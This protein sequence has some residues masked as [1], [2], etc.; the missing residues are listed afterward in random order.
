VFGVGLAATGSIADATA[1]LLSGLPKPARLGREAF[2]SY[3]ALTLALRGVVPLDRRVL[4]RLDR[5]DCLVVPLEL[6]V[7]VDLLPGSLVAADGVDPAALRAR[8]TALI[9]PGRFGEVRHEGIWSV[10][11]LDGGDARDPAT[12]YRLLALRCGEVVHGVA[13]AQVAVDPDGEALLAAARAAGMRVVVAAREPASVTGI[14]ADEIVR[15]GALPDEIRRLQR[16]G[17]VVCVVGTENATALAVA[18]C[19]IGLARRADGVPWA[20]HMLCGDR[21]EDARFLVEAC[22]TARVA[23]SQSVQLAAVGAGLGLVISLGGLSRRTSGRAATAVNVASLIAIANGVRLGAAL[24]ARPAPA[25]RDT[26]PWHALDV[27]AVMER[28]RTSLDGLGAEEALRRRLHVAAAPGTLSRLGEAVVEQLRNPLTPILAIGAGL[29]AVAGSVVDAALVATVTGLNAVVGGVQRVRTDRAIAGLADGTPLRVRVRREGVEET[30]DAGAV[31]PGDVVLLRAGDAVSADCRIVAADNLEVDE[32]SLTGESLPVPKSVRASRV[33]VVAERSSMLYDGTSIVAG[34]AAAIVVAAGEAT[35]TCRAARAARGRK[36][37]EGVEARL[38]SLTSTMMPAAVLS[39][40][41]VAAAELLRGRPGR[42]VLGTGTSLAV[43]AVPEGLPLLALAAQLA[44]ARRLSLRGTLVR[45]PRM[46]EALGRVDVVCFDKTG[47]VTEGRLRL[48]AVWHAGTDVSPDR[49]F[50]RSTLAAALRATPAAP[51]RD[52][53]PHPTDQALV[54]GA[55]TAGVAATDEEPAWIRLAELPFEPERGYH[56]VLGRTG[57]TLR[58]SVKGAPEVLLAY[59]TAW[60]GPGGTTVEIGAAMRARLGQEASRLAGAGFRVLAVAERTLPLDAAFHAGA[61]ADL[62]LRGFV[63]LSDPVRATAG[64]ALRGLREAGVAALL[65]TGDHPGT[66]ARIAAEL[67]IPSHGGVMTGAELD[68]LDDDALGAALRETRV[69]ARVTPAHKVRL[70]AALQRARHTVAMTGD[71][72]NDAA[73]I[74]M[75]DVGIALGGRATPA[76]RAAADLVVTDDRIETIVDAVL[77]G[78]AMWVSVRDAVAVLVGGNVGELGVSV[79]TGL[80]A[81][82]PALNARQLLMVNLFT[83]VAPALVIALRPPPDTTAEALLHEGPEASLGGHLTTDIAWRGVVTAAGAGGA[84]LVTRARGARAQAGTVAL[85]A[86]V[87]S[88]LGQT[89]AT[90]WQSPLIV[91]TALGSFAALGAV[92]QTPG[93]SQLCGCRP[94]GVLGWSTAIVAAGAATGASIAVPRLWPE[95]KGRLDRWVE[96]L[97][98]TWP[99]VASLG[100]WPTP[101]KSART[102]GDGRRTAGGADAHVRDAV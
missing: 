82:A 74:R 92:V 37:R 3:L 65:V 44:A 43:A 100:G 83:D 1:P 95:A 80:L 73:A 8:L 98:R 56:A 67:D 97:G 27:A 4:R 22:R 81:G 30:V 59:C 77:E 28:L 78:R 93:L 31:V 72:A 68:E 14:D 62:V 55:R 20:A 54:D 57:D 32:S 21:I 86:L 91:A 48:H 42:E 70:V 13:R 88:Q 90:G 50:A 71:G 96:A 9:D 35:E 23:S 87:G 63:A 6:L 61:V 15:T 69:F 84:W 29:S 46:I 26:T 41:G 18:D 36:R 58:L 16:A 25:R 39:G 33:A 75:A 79:A 64:I 17:R 102:H 47:T 40:I 51:D 11:P 19:G 34:T 101:A 89:L 5:V 24:A 2:A 85:V 10:G 66:A 60:E 53:L 94:L 52:V 38:E 76:A 7:A 45:N 12:G 49:P 99:P